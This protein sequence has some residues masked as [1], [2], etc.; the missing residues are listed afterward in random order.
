MSARFFLLPLATAIVGLV[1]ACNGVPRGAA[2]ARPDQIPEQVSVERGRTTYGFFT[3]RERVPVDVTAFRIAKRPTT[4]E[5]YAQCVSA[6]ACR[7]PAENACIVREGGGALGL[8]T[9]EVEGGDALPVTCVGIAE[10]QAYC[11]WVGGV[12]PTVTQW[13]TAARGREV[14]RFAW[15][16]R[17]PRCEHRPDGAERTDGVP[18]D[19]SFA[20]GHHAAGSSLFGVEDVLLAPGELIASSPDAPLQSCAPPFAA[21]V[22]YG[23]RPGAIDSAAPLF[24][25]GPG[26]EEGEQSPHSYAFRCAFPGDS[27]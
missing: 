27:K 9:Y 11:A 12:L 6:G 23:G 20:I 15:G 24:G 21:C 3:S 17:L 25:A 14:T 1:G 10:A 5:Q 22:V 19:R 16:N 18:C 8:P 4:V 2:R 7:P 26:T 13:L